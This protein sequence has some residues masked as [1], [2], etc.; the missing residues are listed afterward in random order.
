MRRAGLAAGGLADAALDAALA[1]AAPRV[2]RGYA[3]LAPL[4]PEVPCL[5]LRT[6]DVGDGALLV[7]AASIEQ[8][9][10]VLRRVLAPARS[11]AAGVHDLLQPR[12]VAVAGLDGA[13][14]QLTGAD[15]AH[16]V[17]LLHRGRR[18]FYDPNPNPNLNPNP[19]L[20]LTLNPNPNP[21]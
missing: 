1:A 16:P 11:A 6:A 20:T 3:D 17:S 8:Y 13:R 5:V 9:A 19:S 14:V 2:A 4:V 21:N 12:G 18:G 7:G 10:A 15:H